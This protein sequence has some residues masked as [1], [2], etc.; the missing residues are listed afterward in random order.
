MYI[1]SQLKRNCLFG[2]Y[3]YSIQI[4]NFNLIYTYQGL[5]KQILHLAQQ[6]DKPVV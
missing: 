6:L 5:Y 2:E 4:V 1:H 3:V